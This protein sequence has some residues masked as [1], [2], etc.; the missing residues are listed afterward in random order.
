M[1][2]DLQFG[3]LVRY[4]HGGTQWRAGRHVVEKELR[5]LPLDPWAAGDCV[6]HWVQLEHICET[7]KPAFMWTQFL[8]KATPPNSAT[9]TGQ[10]FG[11]HE[12][13]EAVTIQ[14]STHTIIHASSTIA[15]IE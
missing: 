9:P 4:C 12:S 11:T 5:V 8:Q 10:A 15:I 1:E 14:T 6:P 13:M 3:G 2:A 7:S